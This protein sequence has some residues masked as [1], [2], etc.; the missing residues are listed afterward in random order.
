MP[1]P[2]S[3]FPSLEFSALHRQYKDDSEKINVEQVYMYL[4]NE[5]DLQNSEKTSPIVAHPPFRICF[6]D[7]PDVNS[8]PRGIHSQT[9]IYIYT[10]ILLLCI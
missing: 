4:N 2:G 5:S 10:V 3:C 7:Y 1:E 6:Q 9:Y 8:M